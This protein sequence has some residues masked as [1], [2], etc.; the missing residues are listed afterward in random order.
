MTRSQSHAGS[1]PEHREDLEQG[2]QI[3]PLSGA[4]FLELLQPHRTNAGRL[5]DPL[6]RRVTAQLDEEVSEVVNVREHVELLLGQVEAAVSDVQVPAVAALVPGA[7][8]AAA[9]AAAAKPAWE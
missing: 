2:A 1:R 3:D 5:S 6:P 4:R 9:A 7:K 8:A